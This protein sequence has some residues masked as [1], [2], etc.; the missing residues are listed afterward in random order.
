MKK[1]HPDYHARPV[2][3][4]GPDRAGLLVVGLAPANLPTEFGGTL[5]VLPAFAVEISIASGGITTSVDIPC[6]STLCGLAGYLQVLEFDA[7][8]SKGISFSAGLK[9]L[10]GGSD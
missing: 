6:D 5:N 9:I 1:D 3:S 8:A 2:P 10:L 4:F 7:G